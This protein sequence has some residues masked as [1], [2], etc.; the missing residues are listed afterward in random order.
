[1]LTHCAK[2]LYTSGYTDDALASAGKDIR[3]VRKPYENTVL[4][5]EVKKVLGT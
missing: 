3:L 2:V 4:A 5:K 1:M